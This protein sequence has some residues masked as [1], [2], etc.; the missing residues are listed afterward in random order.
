M[1]YSQPTKH[2]VKMAKKFSLLHYIQNELTVVYPKFQAPESATISK[3]LWIMAKQD[4][5]GYFAPARLLWRSLKVLIKAL[6]LQ[7]LLMG[8]ET[9]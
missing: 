9:K 2:Q 6:K 1:S 5:I 7:I 8:Q 3:R 4:A